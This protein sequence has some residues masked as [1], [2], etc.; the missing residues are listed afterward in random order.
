MRHVIN[1]DS[2]INLLG[3]CPRRSV[4]R[5]VLTDSVECLGLFSRI[6]PDVPYPAWLFMA[7]GIKQTWIVAA[8]LKEHGRVGFRILKQVPWQYWNSEN[9]HGLVEGDD[10]A[11]YKVKRDE[12]ISEN[13]QVDAIGRS[14]KGPHQTA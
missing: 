3:E 9:V 5:C 1:R 14:E 7:K 11:K 12:A 10:P 2:L 13:M 8:L 6:A 4:Q